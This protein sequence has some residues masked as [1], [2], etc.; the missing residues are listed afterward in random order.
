MLL[1]LILLLMFTVVV[2]DCVVNDTIDFYVAVAAA[3]G[4]FL[5]VF[6]LLAHICHNDVVTTIYCV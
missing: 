5:T 2:S 4:I 6:S 3:N 1:L